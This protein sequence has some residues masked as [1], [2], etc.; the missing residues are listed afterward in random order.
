[1]VLDE[2]ST[3]YQGFTK[4]QN[5]PSHRRCITPKCQPHGGVREKRSG[6]DHIVRAINYLGTMNVCT[7]L[8]ANPSCRCFIS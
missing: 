4:F 2:K 6:D 1:M 3:L 7:R 8:C 5:N